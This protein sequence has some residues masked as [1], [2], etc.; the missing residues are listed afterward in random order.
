MYKCD[1]P[2]SDRVFLTT[3]SIM[4]I[5]FMI[6]SLLIQNNWHE[7]S[8]LNTL[9]ITIVSVLVALNCSIADTHK[10][11]DVKY[12]CSLVSIYDGNQTITWHLGL[13][14]IATIVLPLLLLLAG[15]VET[16]PGPETEGK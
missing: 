2:Q 7:F 5:S 4:V 10:Y 6:S 3:I 1:W 14:S 11:S 9:Y 12:V 16:N 15:D 8:L 13:V